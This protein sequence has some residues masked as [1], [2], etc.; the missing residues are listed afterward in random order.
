M[1]IL[2]KQI[3]EFVIPFQNPDSCAPN[4]DFDSK[5]WIYIPPVYSACRYILGTVGSRSLITIG[6]NPSTASPNNLDNTLK[7]VERIAFGNDFDSYIMFNVYAQRATDPS[8]MHK[9]LDARLH[10]GAISLGSVL[11]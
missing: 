9:E 1:H 5:R 2:E 6:I 3:D 7:S 4:L 10:I 8:D 11:F